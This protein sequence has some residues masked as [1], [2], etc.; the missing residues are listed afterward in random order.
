VRLGPGAPLDLSPDGKWALIRERRPGGGLS[1]VPTGPGAARPLL[2]AAI[3]EYQGASFFPDG[4]RLLSW[5]L[6]AGRPPRA[7]VQDLPDGAPRALTPEGLVGQAPI[8][9]DGTRFLA[10]DP[11]GHF[12]IQRLDGGAAVPLALARGDLPVSFSADGRSL[13]FVALEQTDFRR[14]RLDRLDLASGIREPFR[15]LEPAD[16]TGVSFVGRSVR[17]TPDGRT[18]LLDFERDVSDLYFAEGLR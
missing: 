8:S 9:P 2:R 14:A 5:G 15:T 13:Y 18:V 7:F 12:S 6:E 10:R 11:Q 1:L 4:K 17:M 16:L 3:S